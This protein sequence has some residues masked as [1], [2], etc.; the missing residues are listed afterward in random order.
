MKQLCPRN[1]VLV[2]VGFPGH[3]FLGGVLVLRRCNNLLVG[4]S[5]V[6]VAVAR[7]L[8]GFVGARF[9]GVLVAPRLE[10]CPKWRGVI[11]CLLQVLLSGDNL[12]HGGGPIV[13]V[14]MGVDG[15][16]MRHRV[17]NFLWGFSR[18]VSLN[19]LVVFGVCERVL[20]GEVVRFW[21]VG[22]VPAVVVV[23]VHGSALILACLCCLC[24]K[25]WL[26]GA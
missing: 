23:A 8:A 20:S 13:L 15:G 14:F 4:A 26:H 18:V 24:W 9:Y 7:V 12:G 6:G 2:L 21:F 11:R 25:I 17:L 5:L 22:A 1:L 19:V 16:A 10:I 3:F